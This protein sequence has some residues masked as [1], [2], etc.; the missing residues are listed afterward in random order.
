[1]FDLSRIF[2]LRMPTAV[3]LLPVFALAYT[4]S[5][6][7]LIPDFIPCLG[8]LDDL[9][10][11][12]FIVCLLAL[13]VFLLS[14]ATEANQLKTDFVALF[15]AGAAVVISVNKAVASELPAPSVMPPISAPSTSDQALASP[16]GPA[17]SDQPNKPVNRFSLSLARSF[18]TATT[19]NPQM[20]VATQNLAI[21][22]AQIKTAGAVPNP[23]FALQYGWGPPY[24]NTI[25]GNTQ[26]V[27][28][29]Q[30]VEMGGK[31]G[32]RLKLARANYDL[33]QKQLTALH[34][35]V[36]TRVRKAY[37]ELAAAE[38]N[39]E[40][41][42][43]QRAL[44]ERLYAIAN[45]R[46]N[47]G[48]AAEAEAIQAKL[49][50]DQFDTLRTMALARLRQAS[51]QLDYLLGYEPTRDIDVED[52]GLFKLS[53]E[54]NELV[55]QPNF[56][57]PPVEK[58]LAQAMA[59]RPDLKA[60][61]QQ[62]VVNERSLSL[63]KRQAI[64]DVLFGSGYVFST[65]TDARQQNGAYL[66]VNMDLPIFYRKQGEIAQARATLDQSRLQLTATKAQIETDVHAA[67]ATLMAARANII[68]YQDNLIP[69]AKT[70][71]RLAQRTYEVGRSDLSNAIV[72]EQSFQQTLSG[73]FDAVVS[74][75]NAWADLEKAV[76]AP[77]HF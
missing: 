58:L 50:V 10:V 65:Y 32:A 15:L 56:D 40:L 12:L 36:R 73:Y 9:A 29:N 34:L 68:R 76:G 3:R 60:A 53:T 14:V 21:A 71:V 48:A 54:R 77:L 18:D 43:H 72:A 2:L 67:Y 6:V 46:V 19:Q 4:I 70:V 16:V 57:L 28:I 11:A 27:G 25:A 64:P 37:A 38:A 41:V 51:V 17:P 61:N 49:V 59:Q 35:E 75:Q 47:A 7:D 62:I 22:A 23:Q 31:R 24:T 8:L 69:S 30:L 44:I 42:E 63:M 5:P 66:N 26:Q 13:L 33:A 55:P 45:S 1:M 52:N 39:I 20:L 74:Y